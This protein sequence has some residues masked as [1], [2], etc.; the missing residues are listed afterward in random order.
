VFGANGE[1]RE[2]AAP[3]AV[4]FRGDLNRVRP[5]AL[6]RGTLSSKSRSN[7]K[8]REGRKNVI[9]NPRRGL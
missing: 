2:M 1:P 4:R 8:G 6:W 3:R 7:G 5:A 9:A